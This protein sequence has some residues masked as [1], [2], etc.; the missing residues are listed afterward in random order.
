MRAIFGS[1]LVGLGIVFQA[2]IGF[3]PNPLLLPIPVLILGTG[4]AVWF[5]RPLTRQDRR[6]EHRDNIR[7]AVPGEACEIARSFY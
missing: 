2:V 3:S 5:Y 6:D 1:I 4:V 7:R